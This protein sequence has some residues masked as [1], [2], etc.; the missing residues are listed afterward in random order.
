MGKGCEFGLG[1]PIGTGPAH[2]TRM[3]PIELE[4]GYKDKDKV[5]DKDKD[6][7]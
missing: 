6:K 2:G 7:G 4:K 1:L 5:K 3:V